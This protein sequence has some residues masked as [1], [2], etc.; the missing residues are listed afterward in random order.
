MLEFSEK[1]EPHIILELLSRSLIYYVKSWHDIDENCGFFGS[2]TPATFNMDSI[3]SS[4]P[5]IEYVVRPHLQI[6]CILGVYVAREEYEILS[7]STA[8][9][10]NSAINMLKRGINWACETHI[11]GSLDVEQF[12][13][14]KRWGENWR[15]SQWASMLGLCTRLIEKHLDTGLIDKVKKV[16][17][18]EADRFIGVSPPGGCGSD[19]KLEEN[20]LDAMVMAWAI[21]M[22]HGHDHVRS[23]MRALAIWSLNIASCIHDVADH[24]EYLEKSVSKYSS[25]QNLYP[26]MTAENHGFFHPD[27]LSYGMW[28]VLGMAAFTFN[29]Q[30]PPA[31]MRRK[32]HQRTFDV[33]MRFCLPSGLAYTPAGQDIPFFM[34]RPFALAWGLWNNDPRA[35]SLTIKLLSWMDSVLVADDK[36]MGPWVFGFESSAEGWE[37]LFQSQVGFE[38][39]LLSALP[40]PGEPRFYSSGQLEN[41]VDTKHI[42]PYVEVCYRRNVRTTRSV[43][44]KA[45][46]NHPIIGLSIHSY[47]ELIVPY[48][49]DLLGIPSVGEH[50]DKWD[51][52]FHNDYIHK[53]GF[54][55]C[56]RI[57]Y[58]GDK[59]DRLLMRDIRV[60]T[61]GDDGFVIFDRITAEKSMKVE[62]QYLSTLYIVNDFWTKN[63]ISF[64]SGSLR[65]NF[66]SS[67]KRQRET[68]CPSFWA[69]VES[70]II[71][72]FFWGRTKGLVYVPGGR[73]NSPPYW[74]NCRLDMLGV[75]VDEHYAQA[76]DIIYQ[77]GFFI[78]AGKGPRPLKCAGEAGEFF[79]GLVIMDGKNT[80]GI[81]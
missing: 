1:L 28:V 7:K 10:K 16:L 22:N 11:T 79:S 80:T 2:L 38:L 15:S 23:W 19:T 8:L 45:L 33:L 68:S 66:V 17:E 67:L 81:N 6:C 39:A 56:G 42:Y 27:I 25:T 3:G 29:N 48:K 30:E 14:R 65:E 57:A 31:F 71:F 52:L 69:G 35:T 46:G 20:S 4:S 59:G 5:V 18:F 58:Y 63:K 21:N 76:G 24:G 37:L 47:P 32:N 13:E 70:S 43:A 50:I 54:D 75:R 64:C 12:L 40:F 60:L 51:V 9:D 74:K 36:N 72:Q 44:W 49:A 34:P 26:D 77:V 41:A 78:G 53:D 61:W 73:R 62:D 55:T